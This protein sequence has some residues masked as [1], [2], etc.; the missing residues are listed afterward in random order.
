MSYFRIAETQLIMV[1]KSMS[2]L[3]CRLDLAEKIFNEL[4]DIF[5][6]IT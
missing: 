3:N 1:F 4:K 2:G 5:K 6:E